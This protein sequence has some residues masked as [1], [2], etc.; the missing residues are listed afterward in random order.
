MKGPQLEDAAIRVKLGE[1]GQ[2]PDM[3]GCCRQTPPFPQNV[4]EI[5]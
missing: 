1:M 4:S 2:C 3:C 5:V